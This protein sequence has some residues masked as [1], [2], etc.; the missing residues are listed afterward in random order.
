MGSVMPSAQRNAEVLLVE[1]N[2][3]ASEPQMAE[4]WAQTLQVTFGYL[5]KESS[6]DC[7]PCS[8]SMHLAF[9]PGTLTRSGEQPLMFGR[10]F[11]HQ[12]CFQ[13]REKEA[14]VSSG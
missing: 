4:D 9:S 6:R 10:A 11:Y 5:A 14:L 12:E 1:S 2:Q 13:G 3:R 8:S 7:K